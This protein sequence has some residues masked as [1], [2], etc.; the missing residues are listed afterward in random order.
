MKGFVH[1]SIAHSTIGLRFLKSFHKLLMV[2][3]A[4]K[5]NK[6]LTTNSLKLYNF[7]ELARALFEKFLLL[8]IHFWKNK[9]TI[10]ALLKTN[11]SVSNYTKFRDIFPVPLLLTLNILSIRHLQPAFTCSK[12][13]TDTITRCEIC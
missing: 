2:V 5:G 11:F 4:E 8:V 7:S 6:T 9:R 1:W 3:P 13:T 12:L 10:A